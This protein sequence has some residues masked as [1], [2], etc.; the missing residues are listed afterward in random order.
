MTKKCF[1]C[2]EV[3]SLD[4]FYK[5]KKMRD[6]HLNK[7]KECNKKDTMDR[8][9]RLIE[10]PEFLN[11]ERARHREKYRRLGYR[12]KQREWDKN[13]AWKGS[14]FYKSQNKKMNTPNGYEVH[15]WNYN[16]E[17]MM[18]VIF[19]KI[20]EHHKAHKLI[21]LDI[22]LRCYKTKDGEL[23]DTKEKHILHLMKN[24]INH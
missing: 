20:R 5:H 22:E 11:S 1:K 3:K 7:C 2:G 14:V 23:L 13:K 24:K 15:H 10:T 4:D 8:Y 16:D 18:D 6:G 17:F 9:N 21:D 12:E 19:L